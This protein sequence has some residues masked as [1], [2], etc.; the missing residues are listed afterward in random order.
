MNI[1]SRFWRN[2]GLQARLL[3][4]IA[5]I[6]VLIGSVLHGIQLQRNGDDFRMDLAREMDNTMDLLE[7][8]LE[9]FAVTGDVAAI[10]KIISTRTRQE[11]IDEIMWF[12]RSG[13]ALQAKSIA[14]TQL[15]PAWFH[16]YFGVKPAERLRNVVAGGINYG[17]IHARFSGLPLE[18]RLWRETRNQ[19]WRLGLELLVLV[20]VVSYLLKRW[21]KPLEGVKVASRRF[22]QGDF[23]LRK[24]DLPHYVPEVRAMMEA[25]NQSASQVGGLMLSLSEQRRAIDNAVIVVESDLN[26]IITYVN[27]KFCEISGYSREE[28][29]GRDH[30]F[31]NSGHHSKAFFADMWDTINHGE[32]WHGEIL[33]RTRSGGSLWL[34]TTITPIMGPDN[35]LSKFISVRVSITERKLAEN[36]LAQQAQIIDQA[37]DAVFSTDLKGTLVSWNKGA[38]SL[39]GYSGDEAIG[40]PVQL[41]APVEERGEFYSAVFLGL[42]REGGG[43]LETRLLKKSGEAFDAHFSLTLLK[44][45]EGDEIGVVGYAFD[46]TTRKKMERALRES[47][48]RLAKAQQMARLG[49]WEQN[50]VSGEILWSDEVF[51]MFGVDQATPVT[52]ELFMSRVH[53]ED[54]ELVEK[55]FIAALAREINY[56]V[57]IRILP[58]GSTERI[59]HTEAEVEF[60]DCG[61]AVR[62]FG[63][64]QDVTDRKQVE[65]ELRKSR[66]QLRELSSYLQTVREEEKAAIA[67]EIHDELGGNLTAL[68]MDIFWLS[69]KLTAEMEL[70]REKVGSMARLVDASVQAM[71]RIVTDLRPT[72]LD[73]LGLLAAMQWQAAEFSK[74]YGIR[75]K[76]EMHEE[77]IEVG[78]A[79][80]IALFRIFQESLTN[81]ARHSKAT[82]VLVDVWREHDKIA[83]DIIDN[84][85]GIPEGTV[86]QPTSH[87]IRGMVERARSLG[88]TV[89][90][91]S[92]Q[93][94][95]VSISVRIPLP[96]E[97]GVSHD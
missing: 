87:G 83:L 18:N 86:M 46:V 88:G 35:K 84:G 19:L 15:A 12:D 96:A 69:R 30:R 47:E 14:H 4:V 94:E 42:R 16:R 31:L 21:L 57:D 59:V 67:R 95:G 91:G 78:A 41:I 90:I 75:C 71:R 54:R 58:L 73:D 10:Q 66:E 64:I 63:T 80:R 9:P 43:V 56:S 13:A 70:A 52:F 44:D 1:F 11:L 55:S 76:V 40:Q 45:R 39:F 36:A 85:V 34:L 53:P 74:R 33:N 5:L 28:A 62:M 7:M 82:Q 20:L 22:V 60:D 68:K 79:Y 65:D 72:V 81:V 49:N 29:I 89:E 38:E 37:H 17:V 26:G 48:A 3:V 2:L 77:E 51:R 23:A 27:D 25:L 6:L 92:A 24:R 32:T 93:G 50:I 8:S 61:K 97:I